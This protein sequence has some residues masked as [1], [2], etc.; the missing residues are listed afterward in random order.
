M[1]RKASLKYIIH[2][3]QISWKFIKK[4]KQYT[5][6]FFTLLNRNRHASL[7]KIA[8]KYKYRHVMHENGG[9]SP[10]C[11]FWIIMKWRHRINL[12]IF[13]EELIS[14]FQVFHYHGSQATDQFL[15]SNCIE[16]TLRDPK[17]HPNKWVLKLACLLPDEFYTQNRAAKCIFY[18]RR[19][20]INNNRNHAV[21]ASD[22]I[23]IIFYLGIMHFWHEIIFV[24]LCIST[25][26]W[27]Q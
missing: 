14:M 2:T 8:N 3:S 5:N 23:K 12:K 11:E 21:H 4:S 27:S 6:I 22:T 18:H 19:T 16:Y 20:N 26:F 1:L 24:L 25:K 10:Y 13:V 17:L 9:V 15:C 7:K